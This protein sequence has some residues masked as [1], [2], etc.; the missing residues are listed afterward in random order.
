MRVLVVGYNSKQTTKVLKT[1]QKVLA[2]I[3]FK[4]TVDPELSVVFKEM[5]T[6]SLKEY[7]YLP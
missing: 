1:L 2:E 7:L 4:E 3:R 6:D 5:Q